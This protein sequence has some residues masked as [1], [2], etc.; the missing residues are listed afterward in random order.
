M[1]MPSRGPG[2]P[3]GSITSWASDDVRRVPVFAPGADEPAADLGD[4]HAPPLDPPG[5]VATLDR[6]PPLGQDDVAGDGE[7][8]EVE[9]G[10]PRGSQ[11]VAHEVRERRA[12][13][14]PG[15]ER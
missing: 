3:R 11:R 5:A 12:V 10:R 4:A 6:D 14:C 7:V 1:R 15:M 13:E 2:A 8:R 9:G